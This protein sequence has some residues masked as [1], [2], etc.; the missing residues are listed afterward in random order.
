MSRKRCALLYVPETAVHSSAAPLA[1]MLHGAGGNAQHGLDLLRDYAADAN[2]ILLAPESRKSTWDIISDS[3]YGP[4]VL[5][6]DKCLRHVFSHYSI[7]PARV[8]LGGFSDG[9]SYALSLGIS[10]GVL[11]RYVLA[12]SPGFM[13]PMRIEPSPNVF[14]SHGTCDEVLPIDRCSRRIVRLLRSH[15]IAVDYREFDGPHTVPPGMKRAALDL[16]LR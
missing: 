1:I 14:I 4:D 5:F 3:Q 15:Q 16:F 6:I 8:A 12:F 7:D 13:A 9:A 11:F 10:N 2:L